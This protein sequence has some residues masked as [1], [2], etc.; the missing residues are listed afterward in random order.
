L[1]AVANSS[2]CSTC[3]NPA[4]DTLTTYTPGAMLGVELTGCIG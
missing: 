2:C 4:R 1:P 3:S